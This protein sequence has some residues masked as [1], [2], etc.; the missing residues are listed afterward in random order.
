V[1]GVSSLLSAVMVIRRYTYEIMIDTAS[2]DGEED[3]NVT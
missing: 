2:L 1:A 3:G